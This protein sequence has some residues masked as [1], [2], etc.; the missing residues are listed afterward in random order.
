MASTYTS[1]LRLEKQGT[2]DNTG[3]W[4]SRANQTFGSDLLDT[5]IAGTTEVALSSS[6]VTLTSNNGSSDQA[7]AAI[8]K[9]SRTLSANVEVTVPAS[10]KTYFVYNGTSGAFT[11]SIKPSGGSAVSVPQGE[12]NAFIIDGTVARRLTVTA[13]SET[14]SGTVELATNAEA[15]TGTD[16]ARATT[17]ANVKYVLDNRAASETATG[18]VELATNAEA[19]TGTDTARATTPANVKHVLDNRAAS[20]TATG[21]VELAT[22]AEVDAGSDTSRAITPAGL[23]SL[24]RSLAANGYIKLPGGLIVQWGETSAISQDSGS[25]AVTFPL[26]FPTACRA[27]ALS[28]VNSAASTTANFDQSAQLVSKST[29]TFNVLM[30]AHASAA[31]STTFPVAWIAVGH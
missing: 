23:F 7:R 14:A 15:L 1:L 27:V 30:Q 5:A 4:G 29:T 19:L 9:F 12:V 8:L 18:L 20:E 10:S 22:N 6:N 21:L 11:A 26:A 25:T 31:T 17:P 16:T 28:V 2:G 24:A 3:T 13:A